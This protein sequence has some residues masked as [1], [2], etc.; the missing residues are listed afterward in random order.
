[1][2][3]ASSAHPLPGGGGGQSNTTSKKIAYINITGDSRP[4]GPIGI[5]KTEKDLIMRRYKYNHQVAD[6]IQRVAHIYG[7]ASNSQ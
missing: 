3:Y 6:N 7:N 5:K 2:L 4:V 1:V